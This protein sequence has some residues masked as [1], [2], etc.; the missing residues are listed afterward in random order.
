MKLAFF[1][2]YPGSRMRGEIRHR[3]FPLPS[4]LS[5]MDH[6]T[7]FTIVRHPYSR[8]VSAYTDKIKM[9]PKLFSHMSSEIIK[10]YRKKNN[11]K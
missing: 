2:C 7:S 1:I 4:D 6:S 11:K 5:E 9:E 10:R 3:Y 8:L